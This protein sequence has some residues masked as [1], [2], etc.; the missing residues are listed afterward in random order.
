MG[1]TR[2]AGKNRPWRDK[3][4][5]CWKRH[6]GGELIPLCESDQTG[7]VVAF[8]SFFS[9]VDVCDFL[10][11]PIVSATRNRPQ[12]RKVC[13]NP[14]TWTAM[15]SGG[16][17]ENGD[18]AVGS[19]DLALGCMP[20]IH[21][22]ANLDYLLHGQDQSESSVERLNGTVSDIDLNCK[23]EAWCTEDGKLR[24]RMPAATKYWA[25]GFFV[26]FPRG[27]FSFPGENTH[28]YD[29]NYFFNNL[30]KNAGERLRAWLTS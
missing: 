28:A 24:L 17:T 13:T 22:W 23:F 11:R 19:A 18:G 1:P 15:N 12:Q 5:L 3:T 30:R 7:C 4:P 20:I 14:L 29:F 6:L 27:Q 26:P 25:S 8:R 2:G 21:P 16:K 9:D 10:S